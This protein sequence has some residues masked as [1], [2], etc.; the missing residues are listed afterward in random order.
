MNSYAQ[1]WSHLGFFFLD[2]DIFVDSIE[3]SRRDKVAM[4]R[5]AKHWRA[6]KGIHTQDVRIRFQRLSIS[7]QLGNHAISNMTH[8]LTSFL[9]L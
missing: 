7:I 9:A 4:I 5:Y 6:K 1:L 3:T 2:N 8:S